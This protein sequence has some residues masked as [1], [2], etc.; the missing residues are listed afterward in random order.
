MI[1]PSKRA[2]D[3]RLL[4]S[5]TR[6]DYFW[7]VLGDKFSQKSQKIGNIFLLSSLKITFSVKTV[8]TSFGAKLIKDLATIYPNIWSHCYKAARRGTW[9]QLQRVELLADSEPL[10]HKLKLFGSDFVVVLVLVDVEMLI[11]ENLHLFAFVQE[12]SFIFKIVLHK[13]GWCSTTTTYCARISKLCCFVFQNA[14]VCLSDVSFETYFSHWNFWL[15]F[16]SKH[17]YF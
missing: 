11:S 5:V 6:L 9:L 16:S 7:K 1:V 17:C 4:S 2:T 10:M 12:D 3:A 8:G 14:F 13:L 15:L